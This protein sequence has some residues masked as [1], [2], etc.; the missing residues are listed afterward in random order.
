MNRIRLQES[1]QELLEQ[2]GLKW[3][4]AQLVRRCLMLF[5]AGVGIAWFFLPETIVEL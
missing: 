5:A 3:T 2:A 1:T 4:P